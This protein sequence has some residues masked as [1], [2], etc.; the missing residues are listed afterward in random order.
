M[1]HRA[2]PLATVLAVGLVAGVE[3]QQAS[4]YVVSAEWLHLTSGDLHRDAM[5][6]LA[7]GVGMDHP[8]GF[9]LEA[10]YL[11]VARPTTTAKGFTAGAGWNVV[12][13]RFTLRPGVSALVGVA[14][15][16]D[17]LDGYDWQG[18]DDSPFEG[19]TGHQ[20]RMGYARGTTI[21]ASLNLSADY[22]V[23]PGFALT[24]SLRQWVFSSGVLGDDRDRVLAGFGLSIHP[25][26]LLR[27]I[28][29]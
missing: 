4:A 25:A 22:H 16:N 21:G 9:R 27:E 12:R 13:D 23:T 20:E 5:P 2:L 19:G 26:V 6:S 14:E 7:W 10:G 29:P 11:R 24:A 28:N 1:F 15:R 17:D 8:S 18:V 3:A